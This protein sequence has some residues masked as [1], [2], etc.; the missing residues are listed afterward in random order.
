MTLLEQREIIDAAIE[1]KIILG[2]RKDSKEEWEVYD[3]RIT[4]RNLTRI[5]D[6]FRFDFQNFEYKIFK[7]Y[8][9]E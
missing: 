7:D 5:K 3:P 8:E 4:Y 6:D 2:R 9:T 1:K